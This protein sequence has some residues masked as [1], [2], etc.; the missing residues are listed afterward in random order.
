MSNK[1]KKWP[2]ARRAICLLA[3]TFVAGVGLAT[4][5][6]AQEWNFGGFDVNLKS[7]VSAGIGIRTVNPDGD[8]ISTTNGGRDP[9]TGAENFD[10]GNLN[11]RRGD[12]FTASAR[13]L[14]ELD[15]KNGN[16]GAFVSV[17]YFYDFINNDADS[18]RRTDLSSSTRSQAGRGF[19]L[20]DAYAYGNFDVAGMPITIRGG[21]QVI[22]WG[23]ALFRPGG[24]SQTNALDVSRLVTPGTN[25]REAYLPSPMLYVNTS[26]FE[27]FSLEAYYQFQW[28]E[29]ELVPVGTFHST[30]DILGRG[31]QGFFFVGDPGAIGLPLASFFGIPRL[32]DE[33]PKDSGQ[34]G[35]SARYFLDDLAT[36]ASLYYLNYHSKLPYLSATATC[37]IFA[38]PCFGAIPTGYYAYYP[39]NIDLYGASLSF[40][41][42][43]VA[44]GAEVA[45]Q[46]NYPLMLDDAITTAVLESVFSTTASRVNGVA[47]ADRFNY[48]ANVAISVAP[49][50]PY[51]GQ[52]P[53][54]IGADTIDIYGE[55]GLVSFNKA[56]V[57][58]TGD[59]SAW[60]FTT[61]VSAAYTNV[62]MSGL[63]L[64]PSVSLNYDVNGRSLDR[65]LGGPVEGKRSVSV[66]VAA[67]LR[68]T[69]A[70]SISYTNNIGG[71]LTAR[72]ADRD[73]VTLTA[74]YSF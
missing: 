23:E 72:N 56:P 6:L 13:M 71:G 51:V 24:I 60:G 37:P 67:D 55:A 29:T 53:G 21:N 52:V 34:F 2:M 39:E 47:Y 10:D 49:S 36:E 14:H 62:L 9:G 74:S 12:V 38:F 16:Y 31:A 25:I 4:P 18:T 33:D 5:A 42:G 3:G 69:Y 27:N 26:P 19:D 58:V 68:S 54:W 63:K 46:P 7:T 64:T 35:V 32:P 28:R 48:I 61:S 8:L 66:G 45:Y 1:K 17:S 22:N 40:P 65:A 15:I 50:L 70:A 73:F 59:L 30:E 11:F 41:L 43:P 57:G 44:F 20:Y